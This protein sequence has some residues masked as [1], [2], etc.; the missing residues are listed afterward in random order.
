MSIQ[1]NTTDEQGQVYAYPPISSIAKITGQ[2][3]RSIKS[4]IHVL[5]EKEIMTV[6]RS[7]KEGKREKT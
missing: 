7:Y 2:S 1:S 5:E 4:H 6:K 3:E